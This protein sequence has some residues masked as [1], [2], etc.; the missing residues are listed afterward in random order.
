[1][2]LIVRSSMMRAAGAALA[3]LTLMLA[4]A[5]RASAQSEAVRSARERV[6]RAAE[7]LLELRAS[8]APAEG[9]RAFDLKRA[10][11]RDVLALTRAEVES[12][13]ERLR[14]FDAAEAEFVLP[15]EE[16]LEAFGGYRAHL[17]EATGQLDR[18]VTV[19][20]VEDLARELQ[21]W[22]EGQYAADLRDALDLRLVEQNREALRTVDARFT[23]VSIY[24]RI[25][26]TWHARRAELDLLLAAAAGHVSAARSRYVEARALLLDVLSPEVLEATPADELTPTKPIEEPQAPTGGGIFAAPPPTVSSLVADSLAG[27]REAYAAFLKIAKAAAGR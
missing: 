9:E 17:A 27:I 25:V 26:R 15:R 4:G 1:M 13:R 7:H 12:V 14:A 10:A 8:G 18:A 6:D 20:Q 5:P 2:K 16:L 23:R 3:M 24:A 19:A 22:R 11:L 21:S